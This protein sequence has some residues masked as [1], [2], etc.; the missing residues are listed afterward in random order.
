MSVSSEFYPGFQFV[1]AVTQSFPAVMTFS[2]DHNFTPG[3]ILS[4]RI[5]KN[6]GMYQ[7]NNKHARVLSITSD[8]VTLDIET[9]NFDTFI[10]A[11]TDIQVAIPAMALPSSSGVVPNST[12]E[13]TNLL[14]AFDDRP[15]T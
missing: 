9:T 3:E 2:E 11:G 15:T 12:L 13:Q 14:D 1:T 5:P 4:F 10:Y 6:Y 7:L 8:T